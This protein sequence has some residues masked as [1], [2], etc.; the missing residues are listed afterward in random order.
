[1]QPEGGAVEKSAP[2]LSP[3]ELAGSM[4]SPP[5]LPVYRV[6]LRVH[7]ANSS[8]ASQEF[9]PIFN[10][11][12][13]IW[14]SQAGICFEIEAVDDDNTLGDGLDMWFSPYIGGLNG[15]YDGSHIQ[16]TDDPALHPAANSA[17]YSA[18]R[19]AAHELGHALGLPHRQESDDNLMRSK[20]YGWQLS[21]EEIQAAREAAARITVSD[22]A[23]LQCGPPQFKFTEERFVRN[24]AGRNST[25]VA[26][27]LPASSPASR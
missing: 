5:L 21:Q 6:K 18:A 3:A 16:M 15:Y 8:R 9:V 14:W 13:D 4:Q 27:Q 7:L 19:T 1:L 17:K 24:K 12:N 11:I 20:T 23:P 26:P 25:K 2:G 22:T 10:E